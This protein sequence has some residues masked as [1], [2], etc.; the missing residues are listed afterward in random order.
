MARGCRPR[1]GGPERVALRLV[2]LVILVSPLCTAGCGKKGPPLPPLLKIPAPPGNFSAERRGS[3]V[4]LQFTV[5]SANT[6]GTRPANIARV[7]VYGFT[8]PTTVTDA[9]LY[10]RS[11]GPGPGT[12]THVGAALHDEAGKTPGEP[13]ERREAP[14]PKPPEADHTEPRRD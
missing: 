1:D 10:A 9:S 3:D 2:V 11:G 7:D 6:D 12:A 5:P 13:A 8:G 14:A 4:A